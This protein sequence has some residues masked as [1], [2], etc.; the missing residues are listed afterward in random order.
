ME[1]EIDLIHNEKENL[2]NKVEN[3][4]VFYQS[5]KKE[6]EKLEEK[7]KKRDVQIQTLKEQIKTATNQLN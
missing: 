4:K 3:F 7:L 6:K 5:G 1:E 2:E